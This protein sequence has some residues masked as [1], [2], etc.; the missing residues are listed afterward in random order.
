MKKAFLVAL[1]VLLPMSGYAELKAMDDAGLNKITAQ[2]G[3]RITIGGGG[4]TTAAYETLWTNANGYYLNASGELLNSSNG[5]APDEST[6]VL[7]ENPVPE[8]TT[9]DGTV[10]VNG[11]GYYVNSLDEYLDASGDI[12]IGVDDRVLQ[13]NPVPGD[14]A[15][16]PL[17]H[18]AL[19]IKQ[20]AVSTAW[21]NMNTAGDTETGIVNKVTQTDSDVIFIAGDLTI[22]AKTEGA[23][24]SVDIGLPEVVVEKGSKKTELFITHR[25]S[26]FGD[27]N[28]ISQVTAGDSGKLGTHYTDAGLIHIQAGGRVSITSM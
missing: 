7:R 11:E 16:T 4:I 2:E 20:K 28:F 3:V 1:V 15:K 25:T 26:N 8:T 5:V 27:S 17:L 13:Y 6:A 24:S 10:S 18:G 12:A 9:G 19:K 21:T 22:E 14:T 23:V